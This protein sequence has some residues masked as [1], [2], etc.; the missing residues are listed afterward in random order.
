MLAS[1]WPLFKWGVRHREPG[2][3]W[4]V[5]LSLGGGLFSLAFKPGSVYFYMKII[6]GAGVAAGRHTEKG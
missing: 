5:T 1:S 6:G 4:V 2:L 3:N